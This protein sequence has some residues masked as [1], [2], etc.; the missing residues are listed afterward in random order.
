[1]KHF[2]RAQI[3][4]IWYNRDGENLDAEYCH[5]IDD[6]IEMA[7]RVLYMDF[8]KCVARFPDDVM[9]HATHYADVH[10]SLN[11]SCYF[12]RIRIDENRGITITRLK[13]KKS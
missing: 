6:G 13:E 9:K 5:D 8:D 7:K 12:H 11:R 10:D 2:E 1:M 4:V 3:A